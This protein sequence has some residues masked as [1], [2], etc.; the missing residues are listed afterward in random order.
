[1]IRVALTR[2]ER[3]SASSSTQIMLSIFG[4]LLL[5]VSFLSQTVLNH[6]ISD[7]L[8]TNSDSGLV[9][10]LEPLSDTTEAEDEALLDYC[11]N[12]PMA[13]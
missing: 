8:A 1:M 12:L 4:A 10:F 13:D 7:A 9:H 6:S 11:C 3:A 2:F 5:R